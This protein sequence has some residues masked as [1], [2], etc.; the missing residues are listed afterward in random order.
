MISHKHKCIFVHIPKTG[1]S[2]ISAYL[3]KN[4]FKYL[5]ERITDYKNFVEKPTEWAIQHTRLHELSGQYQKFY[6]FTFFRNP[7]DLMVSSFNWW[8]Q[9]SKLPNRRRHGKKLKDLGFRY[10]IKSRHSSCINECYHADQGQTY[11]L[12]DKIDFIGRFENLQEDFN[13]ICDKI[14]IPRKQLPHK[15]KSNHKHYTEYY[16]DE[17]RQIVAEKYAK[18][19]EHFGYE[20]GE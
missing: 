1:G 6:S 19:I 7:W 8:T 17:T 14:G 2:S 4:S 11:W 18:D 3:S 13:T 20:F 12:N 16:D 5:P 15:N 10:F 9:K